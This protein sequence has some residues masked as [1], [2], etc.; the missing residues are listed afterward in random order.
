MHDL[1]HLIKR[2]QLLAEF[3]DFALRTESLDEILT[4]ACSLVGEALGTT[5]AKVLEIQRDE[6]SL[7]VRAGV[8]WKPDIVGRLRLPLHEHSSEAYAIK[9]GKP[10]IIQDI[11][12]E[13]RFDVS[14][15]MKEAGVVALANV[16]ILLPG[17][18][19]TAWCRWTA[20]SHVSSARTTRSSCAPTRR[21]SAR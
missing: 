5:R 21:S 7:L 18:C 20:R 19:A 8:G 6:Q 11:S 14:A 17:G 9:A 3:G 12:K 13:D 4:E 10:V 1:Q 2:Q 15:F 16:P